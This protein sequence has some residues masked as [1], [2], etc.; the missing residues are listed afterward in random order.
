[1]SL[2]IFSYT[3]VSFFNTFPNHSND[4]KKTLKSQKEARKQRVNLIDI[5]RGQN[6]GIQLARVKFS[7]EE[8][9][10]K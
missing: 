5:K 6:A 7:F 9:K 10:K 8:V 2:F 3:H 4:K 1:M